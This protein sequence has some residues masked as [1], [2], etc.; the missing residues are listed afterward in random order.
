MYLARC[1]RDDFSLGFDLDAAQ[2]ALAQYGKIFF[3]VACHKIFVTS[4]FSVK[5]VRR[6]LKCYL[7]YSYYTQQ[8]QLN[9]QIY[10]YQ[11][12]FNNH[13]FMIDLT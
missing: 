12:T 2:F 4:R 7:V 9:C 10:P 11:S 1:K 5:N 13:F 3:V 8:Q 6:N